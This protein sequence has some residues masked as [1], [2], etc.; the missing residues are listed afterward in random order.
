[1]KKRWLVPMLLVLVVGAVGF[2]LTGEK[3]HEVHKMSVRAAKG[4]NLGCEA[5]AMNP[6]REDSYPE[7]SNTVREYYE[8]LEGSA[9]FVE[10]YDN[11]RVY[12]KLGKK[13][14]S[15]LVFVRYEMKIQDIYTKVPGLGTL[16]AEQNGTSGGY[17]IKSGEDSE[18][19]DYAAVISAH[20]DVQKLFAEVNEDYAQALASDALLREAL[21]DL[22]DAYE[23]PA[24]N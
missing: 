23:N 18:M 15:Y 10:S 3:A 6:L 1:M 9:G 20:E 8:Q 5:M 7:L 24:E 21:S 12:T 13:T 11:I 17:E 4:E 19:K 22:R 14:G 2:G 16:Y